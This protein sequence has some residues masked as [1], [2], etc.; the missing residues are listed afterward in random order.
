MIEQRSEGWHKQ[1]NGLLTG[2][3]FAAA[4]RL[5]PYTSAQKLWRQLTGREPPTP[6]NAF[7]QH[8][9]D[10]EPIAIDWYETNTG[11][12][13]A[14]SGFVPYQDWSGV[15][16]DGLVGTDGCIE[17]KC[18]QKLHTEIPI[19]YLPQCIG[20]IHILGREWLDF[21]SWTEQGANVIRITA[22]ETR[23]QWEQ[24][25]RELKQFWDLY[26]VADVEPPRKTRSKKNG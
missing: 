11:N 21:I 22:E 23:E 8:G 16:P 24:W 18:P 6:T 9:I 4:L 2:S 13:V 12:L 1:R 5:C 25:E 26:I 19:H 15:S 14:P 17:V 20:T 3:R 10:H 7:M